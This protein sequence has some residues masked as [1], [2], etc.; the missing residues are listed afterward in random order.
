MLHIINKSPF[1]KNTLDTCLRLAQPGH[2]LLLI[3]DG[4][5]A[6]TQGSAA[7]ERMTQ[8]CANL[9]VFVLQPDL[10]ARGMSAK[11]MPGV[12]LV[13]YGGFV[14][15]VEKYDTSHSWL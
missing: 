14:D 11:L 15:L 10:D 5:Y 6:A 4:I 8:A 1:E 3:E 2:A 9:S 7:Q 12:N 13:D